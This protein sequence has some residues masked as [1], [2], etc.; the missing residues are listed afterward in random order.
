MPGCQ[1]GGP[2][3]IPGGRTFYYSK[4]SLLLS[5]EEFKMLYEKL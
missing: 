1:L 2:G 4:V 5:M 3:S